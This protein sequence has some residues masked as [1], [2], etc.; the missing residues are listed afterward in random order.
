[1]HALTVSYDTG[2]LRVGS[3]GDLNE[4]AAECVNLKL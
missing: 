4:N 3:L 2:R 1:M